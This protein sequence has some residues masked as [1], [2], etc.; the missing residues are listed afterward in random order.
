MEENRMKYKSIRI[1]NYKA[2]K[3]LEIDFRERTLIPFIG[4]NSTTF[5]PK[6]LI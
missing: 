6:F 3:E 1:E 2:I 5:I 4:L